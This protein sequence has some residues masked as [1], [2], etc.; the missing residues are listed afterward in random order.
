MQRETSRLNRYKYATL[1]HSLKNVS[2][3]LELNS[4]KNKSCVSPFFLWR[5]PKEKGRIILCRECPNL[6]E[7]RRRTLGEPRVP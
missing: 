6:G 7:R 3:D 4:I 2:I 5:V 1:E